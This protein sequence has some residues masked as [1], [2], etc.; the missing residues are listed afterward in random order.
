VVATMTPSDSAAPGWEHAIVYALDAETGLEV[1]RRML[2]DPVPVAAMVM[3]A[4]LVHIVATRRSE[5]IYW[6]ALSLEDLAPKSRRILSLANGLCHDDVLDAWATPD[7]GLWLEVDVADVTLDG[8]SPSRAYAF[9]D[10]RGA[11][12]LAHRE[13]D[14]ARSE[15]PRVARD[16]CAEGGDLFAPSEGA[17]SEAQERRPPTLSRLDSGAAERQQS[18]WAR[19]TV[20]GPR[21]ALHALGGEGVIYGVTAAV[22][23]DK[24]DRARVEACAIDRAT[25]AVRWRVTDERVAVRGQAGDAVRVARRSNGELVFQIL[26]LDDLPCTPMLCAGP[27]SGADGRLG[28][29][30]LGARGR[31]VLDAAL[32]QLVLAHREKN[33]GRVEVA[34]FAIDRDGRLLGR[35]AIAAWTLE[36]GDLGGGATVY[37]GAGLIVVRGARGLCAVR[38]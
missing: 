13:V 18:P 17:W 11:L 6:Y 25:A 5:P 1:G 9:A 33:E 37:A 28:A 12:T 31:F 10:S 8:H 38:L 3:D 2:P 26:G 20:R 4:G 14:G 7:G 23:S 30:L 24:T 21:A 34:G 22:D 36:V 19:A 35:R 29:I 15:G 32:G 16:A 27:G